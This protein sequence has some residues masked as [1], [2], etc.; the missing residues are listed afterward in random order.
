MRVV[1]ETENDS[2]AK[3]ALFTKYTEI[4]PTALQDRPSSGL[5][6]M[7]FDLLNGI[8]DVLAVNQTQHQTLFRS[9]AQSL[10]VTAL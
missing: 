5:G 9:A 10:I 2:L 6:T 8:Q 4:L 7:V 3:V 1:P